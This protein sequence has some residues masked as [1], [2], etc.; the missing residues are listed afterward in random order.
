MSTTVFGSTLFFNTGLMEAHSYGPISYDNSIVGAG[1]Q[2]QFYRY[3]GFTLGGEIGI[4][5]RFGNYAQCCNPVVLSSSTLNSGELWF[6]PVLR[7]DGIVLFNVRVI[8]GITVGFSATTDSI[9]VERQREINDNGNA[10]FLGYLGPELAFS[11]L[12]A[13]QLEIFLRV[14]HR[15][16]ANRL[17]GNLME[18]Y[19]ANVLGLRYRY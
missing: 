9:G 17:L 5:D 11:P 12:D 13:S 1:Y 19:N 6:G 15:S 7:Y 2:R 18:G 14:Q 16:G 10:R 8:P 3:G 4:A